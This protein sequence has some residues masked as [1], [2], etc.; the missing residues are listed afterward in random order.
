M[1]VKRRRLGRIVRPLLGCGGCCAATVRAM[2][3][4]AWDKRTCSAMPDV[5]SARPRGPERRPRKSAAGNAA[6]RALQRV[7]RC[8]FLACRVGFRISEIAAEQ[9]RR[10]VNIGIRQNPDSNTPL[11]NALY[12]SDQRGLTPELSRTAARPRQRTQHTEKIRG[13]EAV[14]A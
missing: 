10:G 12:H 6:K 2:R 7:C 4:E 3:Q 8:A 5:R 13:R 9:D 1:A 11:F 14:S